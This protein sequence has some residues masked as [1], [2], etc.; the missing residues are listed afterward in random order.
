MCF[1]SL[2]IGELR[3]FKCDTTI[4]ASSSAPCNG[5]KFLDCTNNIMGFSPESVTNLNKAPFP[6]CVRPLQTL[7]FDVD[8]R[9]VL[10][11]ASDGF[12]FDDLCGGRSVKR[13]ASLF[14][15][16][17]IEWEAPSSGSVELILVATPNGGFGKVSHQ[18]ATIQVD[19]DCPTPSPTTSSPTPPTAAPSDTPKAELVLTLLALVVVLQTI[20]WM[21]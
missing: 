6:T 15:F 10:F 11:Y 16:A 1:A 2:V 4:Q 19:P 20:V 3:Y 21:A 13:H 8:S 7:T 9:V 5:V 14:P 18:S 12:S 17:P